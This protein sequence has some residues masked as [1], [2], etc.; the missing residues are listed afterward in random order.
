MNTVTVCVHLEY[1]E[2]FAGL[3][4]GHNLYVICDNGADTWVIG[5][6]WT[7]LDEDPNRRANLVAFDPEKMKKLGCP[8]V[9]ATTTIVAQNGQW[10]AIIIRDA[11]YNKGSPIS[12]CSEFQTWEAGIAIDSVSRHHRHVDGQ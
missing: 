9:T 7:I 5:D 3:T 2:R 11:V 1:E 10:I 6:G 12:L 4:H 8:I